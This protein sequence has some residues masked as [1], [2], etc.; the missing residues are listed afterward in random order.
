MTE[1]TER[2]LPWHREPLVWLVIAFPLAAV[3]GGFA[4]LYLA[5]RSWDGLVV[6]DYYKKGLE[7]NKVLARDELA[8]QSGYTASVAVDDATVTVRLGSTQ[9]HALPPIIKVS[10]I[11]AT[12]AGLDRQLEI[13]QTSAGVYL[14]PLGSLPRGHWHVHIETTDWRLIDQVVR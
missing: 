6:D 14:A 12:R 10:F 11:H 9:G 1:N 3:I 2:Q 8:Q 4:T 7:I 5:I 13:P